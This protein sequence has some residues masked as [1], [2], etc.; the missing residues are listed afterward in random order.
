[1]TT[2]LM[3]GE[4]LLMPFQNMAFNG[5]TFIEKEFLKLKEKFKITTAIECGS[6]VGGTA[7]WLGENFDKVW[8]IEVNDVFRNICLKRIEGLSNVDSVLCDT[9]NVLPSLL[10]QCDN[11]LIINIDDHW[12][13]K[14]PLIDELKIIKES[15][16]R[17][18]LFI[19]DCKVPNEPKLGYDTWNGIEIS[20][21]TI[22]PYLDEIYGVNGYS[23]HYNSDKESTEIKRGVIYIYPNE[24]HAT[25]TTSIQ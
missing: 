13:D 25:H 19:H 18:V 1:M 12:G 17:P 4:M 21:E 20:Y 6:C 9:L 2:T 8:T 7:K 5:D 15:G 23:Y 16:L 3:E 11:H 14:F 22:K 10:K 24:Q